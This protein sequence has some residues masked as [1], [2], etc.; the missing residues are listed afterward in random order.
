MHEA[1][2][3]SVKL[4]VALNVSFCCLSVSSMWSSHS[5]KDIHPAYLYL[6]FSDSILPSLSV[7]LTAHVRVCVSV[8]VCVCVCV[9]VRVCVCVCV[10]V[11]VCVCVCVCL[12]ECVCVCVCLWVCVC[13]CVCERVCVCVLACMHMHMQVWACVRA[14][15]CACT[16]VCPANLFFHRFMHIIFQNFSLKEILCNV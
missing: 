13:V 6:P 9:S 14:C 16:S 8:R 15:A 7:S 11:R 5:L 10:S 2:L 1:I 3:V 4:V 12:W